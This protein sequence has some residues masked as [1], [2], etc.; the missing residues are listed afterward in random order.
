MKFNKVYK[1]GKLS[2][3]ELALL[4]KDLHDHL[5]QSCLSL[6]NIKLDKVVI[7]QVVNDAISHVFLRY[8]PK[9][10]EIL[11]DMAKTQVFADLRAKYQEMYPSTK[12]KIKWPDLADKRAGKNFLELIQK[13]KSLPKTKRD[14]IIEKANEDLTGKQQKML[15]TILDMENSATYTDLSKKLGV[16][17]TRVTYM[18]KAVYRILNDTMRDMG[19]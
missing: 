10:G 14:E 3:K 13:L 12:N 6:K 5:L 17:S 8:D 16:N 19:I 1:I 11:G 4:Q 15:S 7:E 2:S 18:V 9:S